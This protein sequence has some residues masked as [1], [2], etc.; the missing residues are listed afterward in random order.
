VKDDD[1]S[2]TSHE[3]GARRVLQVGSLK[4]SLAETLHQEYGALVLPETAARD[5]FLDD[6]RASIVAAVT[7]G[8]VGVGTDLLDALPALRAVINFGVGYDTTDVA[9]ARARGIQVS[10][11]PDVLTECVA[12]TAVALVLDTM[13]G[14]SASDRYVRAGS[15]ASKGSFPLA[16]RVSGARIGIVGLGR[17]GRAIAHRLE[18][19]GCPISYHNRHKVDDVAYEYVATAEDL[20]ARVDVL[21]VAAS[22]GVATTGLVSRRVL[23]ALGPNGYLV[24]IARGS[25]VD[26]EAL[27][28]LLL[29]GGLAGAGLDVFANEPHVPEQLL[30]LDNVVLLPHVASGTVETREAM[31]ALTLQNLAAFLSEGEV[32]TPVPEPA[33]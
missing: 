3:A 26:E 17:I 10:N 5:D 15:W 1:M 14:L 33:R 25:V 22:G 28:D 21:V 24:N 9:T 8:R 13:R 2:S 11:T 30:A 4:P 31:E 6:H 7:S 19:F 16:H 23:E 27:V 29:A 18:A 32:L 20:A 12:D